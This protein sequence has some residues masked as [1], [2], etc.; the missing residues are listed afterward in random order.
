TNAAIK[1]HSRSR[2]LQKKNQMYSPGPTKYVSLSGRRVSLLTQAGNASRLRL[3][4]KKKG[5]NYVI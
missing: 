5:G 3:V 2:L 4:F 1:F